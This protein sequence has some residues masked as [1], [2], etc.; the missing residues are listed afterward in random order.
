MTG[1]VIKPPLTQEVV[2]KLHAGDCVIVTGTVYTARD[3][4]HQRMVQAIAAGKQLPFD[5]AGQIIYYTGPC[6]AFEQHPIGSCGPTTSSRM[7]DYTLDLLKL[8]LRG[9]IGKGER[10]D[11]VCQ[12]ISEY[13]A[14][15]LATVGG[16]GTYLAKRVVRSEVI[17]YPEL[18]TEAIAKLEVLEFPCI[19]AVDSFGGN[20][21]HR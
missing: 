16:A 17:A 4:A 7:D 21:Y 3:A 9:M 1:L 18:G 6:P 8:G 20:L 12:A 13:K 11:R 10:S 19:V 15:Y 14:V 5:P 2:Q